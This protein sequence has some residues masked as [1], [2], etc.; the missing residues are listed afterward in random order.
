MRW[1]LI[2]VLA[3]LLLG[4]DLAVKEAVR[5][6]ETSIAP[7]LVLPFVVFVSL[8][9]PERWVLWF[10]LC[11]GAAVDLTSARAGGPGA[12]VVPGPGALGFLLGAYLV[13]LVRPWM[14]RRNPRSLVA[15][16]LV[17]A[18]VAQLVL[19]F[20]MSLRA[21]YTEPAGWDVV[22]ESWQ[23]LVSAFYTCG[24]SLLMA[25]VLYPSFDVFGFPVQHG[26]RVSG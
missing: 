12:V 20:V 6:G 23:R 4:I 22:S 11:V 1:P 9:A 17:C 19:M 26:R 3:Y 10:A 2:L 21:L 18:L 15:M 14:I 5:I 24:V 7:S 16:S 13:V 8:F 25:A